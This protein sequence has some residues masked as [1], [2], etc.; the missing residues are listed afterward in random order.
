MGKLMLMKVRDKWL[1]DRELLEMEEIGY[2]EITGGGTKHRDLSGC[3]SE[4]E[5]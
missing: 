1:P 5:Q 4:K 2:Y 3:N